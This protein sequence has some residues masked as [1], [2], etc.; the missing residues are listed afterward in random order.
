MLAEHRKKD[1][2]MDEYEVG[3]K[4]PPRHTRFQ[5]GNRANPKGRVKRPK[6]NEGELLKKF[7]N[8]LELFRE[9]G[10]GKRKRAPRSQLMVKRY[11]ADAL[12]GDV[13]SAAMLLKLRAHGEK[14]GDINPLIL[15]IDERD[16]DA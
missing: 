6:L 11:G 9:G 1:E 5:K 13:G 3:Y 15:R 4:K 14:Y 7:F 8:F 2:K 10:K 16:R 12:K